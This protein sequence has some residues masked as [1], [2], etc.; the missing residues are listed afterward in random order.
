MCVVQCQVSVRQVEQ[1]YKS[2][3]D[4]TLDRK[5][6]VHSGEVLR[7]T[8]LGGSA[9][10]AASSKAPPSL[11][12]AG[13]DVGEEGDDDD[14]DS[15]SDEDGQAPLAKRMGI[16]NTAEPDKKKPKVGP[17][18][19]VMCT[20]GEDTLRYVAQI[21]EVDE[22]NLPGDQDAEMQTTMKDL[23]KAVPVARNKE[24]GLSR[25]ADGGSRK[26]VEG[27]FACLGQGE[28][29]SHEEGHRGIV[30]GVDDCRRDWQVQAPS[31]LLLP[32]PPPPTPRGHAK[33]K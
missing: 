17:T 19:E 15:H 7:F 4:L 1:A 30:E 10:S 12:A 20:S 29:V 27:L 13:G 11:P 9:A 31:D 8:G 28:G 25:E 2:A 16:A 22:P 26:Q 33:Q 21:D 5:A 6:S 3:V 23:V 18:E 14:D 24:L 32:P